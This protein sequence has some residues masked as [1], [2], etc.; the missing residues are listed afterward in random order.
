MAAVLVHQRR[1]EGRPPHFLEA[2]AVRNPGKAIEAGVDEDRAAG[3]VDADIMGVEFAGDVHG[4]WHVAH[5][6]D[7]V[8]ALVRIQRIDEA[9]EVEAGRDQEGPVGRLSKAHRPQNR[10][11]VDVEPA[12][13]RVAADEV[14]QA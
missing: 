10:R 11:L 14:E 13:L 12:G 6:E 7:F 9:H 8:G 5:V 1:Y 2:V 3:R 4:P